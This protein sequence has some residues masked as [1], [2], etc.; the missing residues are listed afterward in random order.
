M[1]ICMKKLLVFF[2]LLATMVHAGNDG[3]LLKV[4]PLFDQARLMQVSTEPMQDAFAKPDTK[5]MNR[6]LESVIGLIELPHGGELRIEAVNAIL[7]KLVNI[8]RL[9]PLGSSMR[10]DAL[11]ELEKN[12]NIILTVYKDKQNQLKHK[13]DDASLRSQMP[14]FEVNSLSADVSKTIANYFAERDQILAYGFQ[15]G[16]AI[17][18][19]GVSG[20]PVMGVIK[21]SFGRRYLA[22]GGVGQINAVDMGGPCFALSCWSGAVVKGKSSYYTDGANGFVCGVGAERFSNREGGHLTSLLCASVRLT[23]D[24]L[25]RAAAAKVAPIAKTDYKHFRHNLGIVYPGEV[26]KAS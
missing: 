4:N 21:N 14:V 8:H 9:Y 23:V 12:T 3:E 24:S 5:R 13:E 16:A 1:G 19:E 25:V 26:R 10:I 7:Q 6:I 20:G 22:I 18:G 11:N 17:L 15:V 2:V